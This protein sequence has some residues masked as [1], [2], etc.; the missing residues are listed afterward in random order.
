MNQERAGLLEGLRGIKWWDGSCRS[1]Q[2]TRT[3]RTLIAVFRRLVADD[4][5][6]MMV[7][8]PGVLAQRLCVSS[9][10]HART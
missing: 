7:R 10:G 8:F 3:G 6:D 5:E 1:K 2:S 9:P 4:L